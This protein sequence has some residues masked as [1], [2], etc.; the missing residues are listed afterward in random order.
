MK[1]NSKAF[2]FFNII[3]FYIYWWASFLGVSYGYY[4]FGPIF[5]LIYLVLHFILI[6]NKLKEFKFI[7]ICTILGFI[8]ETSFLKLDIIEYRG[9]LTDR[10]DIAPLWIVLLWSGL[11]STFFHSFKWI[12]GNY[13]L[14]IPLGAI[15]TPLAYLYG[16]KFD[17]I[18]FSYPLVES[19]LILSI[20]WG[21]AFFLLIYIA[22]FFN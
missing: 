1:Y 10:F 9:I 13:K 8:I 11:A 6:K 17:I 15:F 19:Y 22:D 2:L 12:L 14:G 5:T 16:V 3:S 18:S 4:Y 7:M 20:V 21:F